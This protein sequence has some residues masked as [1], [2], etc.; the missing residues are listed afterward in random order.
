MS[1]ADVNLDTLD[2]RDYVTGAFRTAM[3]DGLMRYFGMSMR[4]RRKKQQDSSPD[5]A[6]YQVDTPPLDGVLASRRRAQIH[7]MRTFNRDE[8]SIAG[9]I[10]VLKDI[11]DEHKY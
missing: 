4:K 7:T 2:M 3:G 11:C 5:G 10:D 6:L 1:Y 9:T 8:A